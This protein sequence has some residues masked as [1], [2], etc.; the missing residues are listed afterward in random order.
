MELPA[1]KKYAPVY[2]GLKDLAS[3]LKFASQRGLVE[4]FDATIGAGSLLMPFGGKNQATPAQAMAAKL[5]VLPGEVTDAASVMAW[6]CDP[7]LLSADPF[8]GA[9]ASVVS[10]MAKIVAAGADYKKA[11]LT[12]QEFFEKLRNEPTRW[13]KPFQALLGAL[14]AQLGLGAAAIGGKDS[15]SGTFLDKD[16]PP[17]VISFAIAPLKAEEVISPEFKEAGHP[18]YRFGPS[19][20][21]SYKALKES[22]EKFHELCKAGKVVAAWAMDAGGEGEA[23]MKMSFGNG[24]GFASEEGAVM[25]FG[26]AYGDIVAELTEDCDFGFR[27][28]YTTAEPTIT[29][30]DESA[31]IA[32]LYEMNTA[33]LEKVYPTKTVETTEKIPAFAAEG[34]ASLAPVVK[35]A[36]PRVLI[37]VFPGTNCEYDS[38]RAVM[39]AGGEV[40]YR[41]H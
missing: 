29:I 14:D 34:G 20:V 26:P 1:G 24:I 23:V 22:W 31:T 13:G 39:A 38:A 10:S 25:Q 33:V 2:T 15:M 16:V 18:V 36:R 21:S 11:Y 3:Q 8:R 6:G 7:E 35:T 5:P 17:T 27:I 37:P 12:L 4:R 41:L 28:G 19:S 30:R 40:L 9:Q 32:E